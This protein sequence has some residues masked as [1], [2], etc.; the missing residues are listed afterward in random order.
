MPEL[1][2]TTALG[3]DTGD[4]LLGPARFLSLM[5][6]LKTSSVRWFSSSAA[7]ADV[8]LKTSPAKSEKSTARGSG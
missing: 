6:K 7:L 1:F 3:V 2:N 8:R 4:D 5:F